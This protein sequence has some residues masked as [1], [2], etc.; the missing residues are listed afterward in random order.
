MAKEPQFKA[1]VMVSTPE[2]ISSQLGESALQDIL[3]S[4][5]SK[6]IAGRILL[7]S[8]WVLERT[9]RDLL[10]A[11]H[12]YLQTKA[13]EIRVDELECVTNGAR[14]CKFIGEWK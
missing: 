7:P 6:E 10:I 5:D 4:F 14:C 3:G 11:T 9:H 12:K 8:D 13:R 1:S 2:F